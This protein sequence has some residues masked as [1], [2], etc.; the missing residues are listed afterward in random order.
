MHV[1]M[2]GVL[3]LLCLLPLAVIALQMRRREVTGR[4]TDALVISQIVALTYPVLGAGGMIEPVFAVTAAIVAVVLAVPQWWWALAEVAALAA[5]MVVIA[6]GATLTGLLAAGAAFLGAGW[7]RLVLEADD[8]AA[9]RAAHAVVTAERRERARIVRELHDSLGQELAALRLT[10]GMLEDHPGLAGDEA[11]ARLLARSQELTDL[12]YRDLRSVIRGNTSSTLT[13]EVE[14]LRATAAIAGIEVRA[15][16]PPLG[17][18]PTATET[19]LARA[20][21]EL[22]TNTVR[23]ARA[24]T[25][26]IHV[27]T[28]PQGTTLS[29]EDDGV[30]LNRSRLRSDHG[31][32][33]LR[34]HLEQGGGSV[35]VD[36]SPSGTAV[37]VTVPV[38]WPAGALPEPA[39]GDEAATPA[40]A[41]VDDAAQGPESAAGASAGRGQGAAS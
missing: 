35:S 3:D 18:L 12:A 6:G 38:G 19:T 2:S 16:V 4:N 9:R 33:L 20:L 37:R 28:G 36:S 40:G 41:G 17:E 15:Q 5:T 29:V 10:L 14:A 7:L 34:R 21:R 39:A 25:V 11:A 8:R 31:L 23:H 32:G 22:G 1:W 27:S 13:I 30:G 24:T 26:T